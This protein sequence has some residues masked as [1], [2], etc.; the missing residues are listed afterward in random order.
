MA[1]RRSALLILSATSAGTGWE[2]IEILFEMPRTPLT[3]RHGEFCC[4]A[5]VMMPHVPSEGYVALLY[6]QGDGALWDEPVCIQGSRAPGGK[7]RIGDVL[8]DRADQQ[9]ID[10]CLDATYAAGVL[11]CERRPRNRS[12]PPR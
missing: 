3:R 5:L 7:V 12:A 9:V 4:L 10:H 8:T 2:V 1:F 6:V 11:L